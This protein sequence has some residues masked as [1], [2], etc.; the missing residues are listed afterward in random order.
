[1]IIGK[2]AGKDV[3]TIA[4]KGLWGK[5]IPPCF[6]RLLL[7]FFPEP[8]GLCSNRTFLSHFFFFFFRYEGFFRGRGI[9]PSHNLLTSEGYVLVVTLQASSQTV[10][11]SRPTG[12]RRCVWPLLWRTDATLSLSFISR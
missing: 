12:T 3:I 1:M 8:P 10:A 9:S 6:L 5:F 2:A 11:V 4:R 7:S